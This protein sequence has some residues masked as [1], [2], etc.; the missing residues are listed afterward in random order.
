M[1]RDPP[2]R[3]AAAVA[4]EAKDTASLAVEDP[5]ADLAD[6]ARRRF[7]ARFA[8]QPEQAGQ[9]DAPPDEEQRTRD[10]LGRPDDG[11][12]LGSDDGLFA[13]ARSPLDRAGGTFMVDVGESQGVRVGA[14]TSTS[15]LGPRPAR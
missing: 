4:A 5:C 15:D 10:E 8:E 12:A 3:P 9:D 6:G 11:M 14:G 13:V 7:G 2:V 1:L